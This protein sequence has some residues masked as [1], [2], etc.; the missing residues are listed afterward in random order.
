M[1][2]I[3]QWLLINVAP[4]LAHAY[5]RLLHAT[6]RIEARGAE[7]LDAARRDAGKYVLCFWHSRFVLMPY[8][9][10]VRASSCCPPITATPRRSCAS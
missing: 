9:Y 1:R 10:P 5:I 4:P 2:P 6:M 3:A 8:C 7:V